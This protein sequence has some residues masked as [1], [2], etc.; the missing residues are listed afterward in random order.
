MT[1]LRGVSLVLVRPR[2]PENIG[3]AVRVAHNFGISSVI[4]VGD[5]LPERSRMAKTATHNSAHLLDS[6]SHFTTLA[7][8]LADVNISIATTAR[9]GRRRFADRSPKQIGEWLAPRL[10]KNRVAL[11]FGPEDSGLSNDE[12]KYCQ[13][14]SSIPTAGFSSLNLAQAVAV[15]CYELFQTVVQKPKGLAPKHPVAT[16]F[17][18]ESMFRYL[19]QALVTIDFVEEEGRSPWMANVRNFLGRMEL[20]S[21]DADLIRRICKKFIESQ[22]NE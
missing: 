12:L 8:A 16:G 13:L 7:D 4:L 5:T 18:R 10:A 9:K 1:A 19:E 20:E 22:K 2:V 14:A 11:L 17:E 6:M 3:S 15:Y 21:R